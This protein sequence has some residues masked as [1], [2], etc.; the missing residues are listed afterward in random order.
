MENHKK[1]KHLLRWFPTNTVLCPAH[2]LHIT[3]HYGKAERMTGQLTHRK[4]WQGSHGEHLPS[5]QLMEWPPPTLSHSSGRMS[6]PV[7][8]FLQM[9]NVW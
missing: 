9:N 4:D 1:K 5:R 6:P 8:S 7:C 2:Y 3:P